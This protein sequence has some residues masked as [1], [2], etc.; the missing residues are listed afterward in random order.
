MN[1]SPFP[2]AEA[3]DLVPKELLKKRV[4][5]K[6]LIDS[7]Y[8]PVLTGF[9]EELKGR[10]VQPIPAKQEDEYGYLKSHFIRDTYD[11]LIQELENEAAAL[12]VKSKG[13]SNGR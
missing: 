12:P 9:I 2:E 1:R 7:E 8:W 11:M 4:S 10:I 3:P 13:E 6:G 5:I